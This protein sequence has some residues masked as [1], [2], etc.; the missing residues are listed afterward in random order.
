M[1][2]TQVL[3]KYKIKGKQNKTEFNLIP[4]CSKDRETA[5]L[6]SI[7][8]I[9]FVSLDAQVVNFGSFRH[10]G[11]LYLVRMN[12][13]TTYWPSDGIGAR[14]SSQIIRMFLA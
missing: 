2:T 8:G 6:N 10:V 11:P 7:F 4:K 1:L 12:S 5:E 13:Y 3:L 9:W 14:E